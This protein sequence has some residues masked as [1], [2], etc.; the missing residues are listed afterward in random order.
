[1]RV[2]WRDRRDLAT[3]QPYGS[4]WARSDAGQHRPGWPPGA[5]HSSRNRTTI[6]PS[7]ITR[8]ELLCAQSWLLAYDW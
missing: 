4:G 8:M 6:P 3:R 1:M 5:T 7:A 2:R